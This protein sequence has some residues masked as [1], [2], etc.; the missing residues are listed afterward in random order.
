MKKN[1]KKIAV[2]LLL[3][4]VAVG[5]Y[6]VSGTY[7]KYTK[8]L[9]GSDTA[10]VAKFSVSAGDLT[11]D[12]ANIALFN[13]IK[14]A[15]TNTTE[16]HVKANLIAPGTGGSFAVELTNASEVDVKA[17]IKIEETANEQQVPIEYTTDLTANNWA[18]AADFTKTIDH[19]DYTG[20]AS[21]TSSETVTIYWRWAYETTP[22]TDNVDTEIGEQTTA[23]T[24]TAKVTATFT[25]ID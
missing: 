19:L 4:V 22:L 23:P 24:V 10:T 16:E 11:A 13:T 15:D 3:S 18:K 20:K 5:S 25:Q 14:E 9:S 8:A 7:A 17:V 12:E 1:S 2:M 21:G 6:F